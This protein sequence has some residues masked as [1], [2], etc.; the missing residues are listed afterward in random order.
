MGTSSQARSSWGSWTRPPDGSGSR[1]T[2]PLRRWDKRNQTRPQSVPGGGTCL[3]PPSPHQ[4]H[5]PARLPLRGPENATYLSPAPPNRAFC[6]LGLPPP[7]EIRGCV[8]E[9]SSPALPW[10]VRR[11]KSPLNAGRPLMVLG[12][13]CP[14]GV[15]L[16]IAIEANQ[17]GEGAVPPPLPPCSGAMSGSGSQAVRLAG[18]WPQLGQIPIAGGC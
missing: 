14:L 6:S 16:G 1:P 7:P 11:G 2:L 18:S 3:S 5:S 4:Q 13:I 12:E 9:G 10:G 17:M 15:T 8:R